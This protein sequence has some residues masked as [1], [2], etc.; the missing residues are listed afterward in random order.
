MVKLGS[1]GFCYGLDMLEYNYHG[2]DIW[3]NDFF[4]YDLDIEKCG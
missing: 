2:I 4:Y 1:L 3:K